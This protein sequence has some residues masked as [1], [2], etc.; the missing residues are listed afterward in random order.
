VQNSLRQMDN[1]LSV[2]PATQKDI[3]AALTMAGVEIQ[4]STVTVRTVW[5]TQIPMSVIT[6]P[7][8]TVSARMRQQ[9]IPVIAPDLELWEVIA[10]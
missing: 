6:G 2:P 3:P 8:D 4:L 7:A 10:E 9:A 5:I 1:H